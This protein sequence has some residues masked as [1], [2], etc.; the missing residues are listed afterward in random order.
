MARCR[1]C[2][3]WH[4]RPDD[5]HCGLC[6][7]SA[8]GLGLAAGGRVELFQG[9]RESRAE[10]VIENTGQANASFVLAP[11]PGLEEFRFEALPAERALAPGEKTRVAFNFSLADEPQ[12][13]LYRL[14]LQ[15]DAPDPPAI[16]FYKP[17]PATLVA[18]L[19]PDGGEVAASA[20]KTPG[21]CV[22]SNHG[23]AAAEFSIAAWPEWLEMLD[24]AGTPRKRLREPNETGMHKDGWP[25]VR[26]GQALPSQSQT[27]PP[28][29]SFSLP[30]LIDPREEVLQGNLTLSV[31]EGGGEAREIS[32]PLRLE[33]RKGPRPALYIREA[34]GDRP[35]G[36][37]PAELPPDSLGPRERSRTAI[38]LKNE[39]D[40]PLDIEGV[41]LS[42]P[43]PNPG[44]MLVRRDRETRLAPGAEVEFALIA[45]AMHLDPAVRSHRKTVL[46]LFGGGGRAEINAAFRTPALEDYTGLVAVDFGTT[47]SCLA[48]I[49]EDERAEPVRFGNGEAIVPSIAYF[50]AADDYV[51]GFDAAAP[52]RAN[53]ANAVRSIKRSLLSKPRR[54]HGKEYASEDIAAILIRGLL[55]QAEKTLH[56]RVRRA[57]FTVPV[58]FSDRHRAIIRNAARRFVDEAVIL[59]EPTAAAMHHIH[60]LRE[61][62]QL[63]LR[64]DPMKLAV[65]DFGGGTLDIAVLSVSAQRVEIL[66]RRG[67]RNLG[68]IDLDAKTAHETVHRV[69]RTNGYAE[70]ETNAV[71]M[72]RSEFDARFLHGTMDG[73][74][75]LEMRH[76]FYGKAEEAKIEL[77]ASDIATVRLATVLAG[78]GRNLADAKP[79]S[80]TL[81]RAEFD[82]L[83]H[84]SVNRALETLREALRGAGLEPGDIDLALPTGQICRIPKVRNELRAFFSGGRTSI[85]PEDSFDPKLCVPL[86]AARL[87]MTLTRGPGGLVSVDNA[88]A[89]CEKIGYIQTV[90]LFGT[91][92]FVPMLDA[93]H[94]YGTVGAAEHSLTLD[95]NGELRLDIRKNPNKSNRATMGEAPFPLLAELRVV[96]PGKANR[97]VSLK[98]GLD[99]DGAVEAYVDGERAEL[100]YHGET[101]EEAWI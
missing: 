20:G 72:R 74:R 66:S 4:I 54:I 81:K 50:Y 56:R 39:G 55:S 70:V 96:K 6:G 33:V 59:D 28:H 9:I 101:A 89:S 26:A 85:P 44:F 63:A 79:F 43:G 29:S 93:N 60:R 3:S 34:G 99:E 32:L 52:A 27:L 15:T 91:M 73:G 61:Q 11:A 13:D 1:S 24:D 97:Y 88:R 47:N 83:I 75:F 58:D 84:D 21:L 71:V 14:P 49:G 5:R 87:A 37:T 90:D 40:S 16:V 76:E 80:T 51:T 25:M 42:D 19:A 82:R 69:S 57:A 86:G 12:N 35:L 94:P 62:G 78:D 100:R 41:Y 48:A 46:F 23:G 64:E 18:R 98:L 95:A 36:G 53:P 30:V 10:A 38:V 45:D 31:R 65:F 17:S 22:L 77:S 68:G 7:A 8:L 2:R 67:N 92:D